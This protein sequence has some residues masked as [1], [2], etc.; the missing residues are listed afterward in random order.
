MVA[1]FDACF[2][3]KLTPFELEDLQKWIHEDGIS[4]EVLHAAL[5]E[6][7]ESNVIK[8]KYFTQILRNWQREGID[9]LEKVEQ[10]LRAHEDQKAQRQNKQP[11]TSNVP[12]WSD[13]DY[14]EEVTAEQEAEFDKLK[15]DMMKRLDEIEKRDDR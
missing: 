10:R 7:V 2:G 11:A 9:S 6:M 3:R 8:W 5:R 1:K 14:K 4:I 15:A 13:P 12:L